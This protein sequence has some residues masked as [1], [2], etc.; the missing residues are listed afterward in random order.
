VS[1]LVRFPVPTATTAPTGATN[2][3]VV[4]TRGSILVDPAGRTPDLDRVVD[5]RSV[6]HLLVTHTHPDHVGAVAEYAAA[7]GATVWA[8]ARYRERFERATGVEPNRTVADGDEV[9]SGDGTRV[10]AL[11]APGHAPDHLAFV[12]GE[13]ILVGDLGTAEGSVLVGNDGDLTAYLASLDR[14]LAFEPS[15]CYPGHGPP[16]EDPEETLSRLIDHRLDRE[17]RVLAAVRDGRETVDAILD[18]AYERDL[19]GIEGLAAQAVRAHLR[20]LAAEGEI[21]WNGERA[22]PTER[23]R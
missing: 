19:A 7:T 21:R 1:P 13:S 18:S 5:E 10:V 9:R 4:G 14:L 16:I 12:V 6:E 20:K 11:E 2:A 8:H 22:I 15:T 3:Y 17:R 23:E